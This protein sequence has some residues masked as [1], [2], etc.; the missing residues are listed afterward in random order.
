V[1]DVDDPKVF[2]EISEK[3]HVKLSVSFKLQAKLFFP[4]LWNGFPLLIPSQN[5]YSND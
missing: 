2:E 4:L 5:I 3:A 1:A